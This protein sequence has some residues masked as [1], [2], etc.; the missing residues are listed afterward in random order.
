MHALVSHHIEWVMWGPCIALPALE[1]L[2][3]GIG[4][5]LIQQ[6]DVMHNILGAFSIL[7]V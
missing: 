2:I 5:T 3:W 4:I 6:C 7:L 1:K